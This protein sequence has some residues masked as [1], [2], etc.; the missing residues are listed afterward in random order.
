MMAAPPLE[1]GGFQDRVTRPLPAVAVSPVGGPGLRI[2]ACGSR[3]AVRTTDT[4]GPLLP[5]A[6]PAAVPA[7]G[8]ADG[9]ADWP[10]PASMAGQPASTAARHVP[11]TVVSQRPRGTA[12]RAR[13]VAGCPGTAAGLRLLARRKGIM[14][15]PGGEATR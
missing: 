11:A 4:A 13:R 1:A 14:G 10:G 9:P 6:A 15:S 8:P 12:C 2:R 7:D 5:A 3:T